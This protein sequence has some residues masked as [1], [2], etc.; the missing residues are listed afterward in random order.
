M[1]STLEIELA[2][3][4]VCY[5]HDRVAPLRARL[6]RWGLRPD[7]RLRERGVAAISVQAETDESF[8]SRTPAT[9]RRC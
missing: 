6:Y 3:A 7:A 9:R 4:D 1:S 5:C 2:Q 8:V